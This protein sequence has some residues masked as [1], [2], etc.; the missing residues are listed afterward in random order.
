MQRNKSATSPSLGKRKVEF[1]VRAAFNEDLIKRSDVLL[2]G[3]L[4][5][6]NETPRP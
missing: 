1:R 4:R 3:R 5:K 6:G 2:P